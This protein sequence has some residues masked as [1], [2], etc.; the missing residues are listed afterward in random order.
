[1][2]PLATVL[3]AGGGWLNSRISALTLVGRELSSPQ[4]SKQA[5]F[6]ATQG[7]ASWCGGQ[8]GKAAHRLRGST[9]W[10]HAQCD[11][12]QVTAPLWPQFSLL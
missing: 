5:N 6:P 8:A 12:G 9:S 11:P 4:L 1:M 3:R 7:D 2:E 10:L